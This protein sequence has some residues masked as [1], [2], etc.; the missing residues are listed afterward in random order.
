MSLNKQPLLYM[1]FIS[2]FKKWSQGGGG[3]LDEG[4]M[5]KRAGWEGVMVGEEEEEEG[6]VCTNEREVVRG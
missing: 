5:G 3:W 6:G 4:S 1:V 2:V